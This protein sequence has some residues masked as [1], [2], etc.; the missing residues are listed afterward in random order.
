MNRKIRKQILIRLQKNNPHPMPQLNGTSPFE[1]LIATVL[2]AQATDVSVN[3]VT[4]RLYPLANT[5]PML[6]EF[7]IEKLKEQ[8]KT[9]G[10]YNIKAK[11]IINICHILLEKHGGDVPANLAALEDLPGVGRKTANVVLNTCFHWPV[12]AVDRHVFRVCNRSRFAIGRNVTEV[13]NKLLK[14]VPKKFQI[15]C[16][17]W[18][19]LH[20]RYTCLSRKP[21][22]KSCHIEDL[23]EFKKTN[24]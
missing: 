14:Y 20:G 4:T 21:R 11:N 9:I 18:F 24:S 19:I 2:S 3:K 5:A 1:I 6:L 10:L 8:I 12:I 16:H 15:H 17:Q 7:G 23:C 13:E 22:C